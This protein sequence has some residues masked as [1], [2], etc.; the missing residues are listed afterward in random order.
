[1]VESVIH[2]YQAYII[3]LCLAI[4]A[5]YRG[6]CIFFRSV[7]VLRSYFSV[8]SLLRCSDLRTNAGAKVA[9]PSAV[10]GT[11]GDIHRV[12]K[13]EPSDSTE[14]GKARPEQ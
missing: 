8:T 13:R 12:Q 10:T 4:P 2:L 7:T 11:V 6:F 5:K 9:L 1:M 3:S 14:G